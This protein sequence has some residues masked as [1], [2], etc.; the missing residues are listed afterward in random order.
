MC[1]E[2][3]NVNRSLPIVLFI[4]FC[5]DKSIDL[6]PQNSLQRAVLYDSTIRC[7]TRTPL[8]TYLGS[9]WVYRVDKLYMHN[10]VYYNRYF[11]VTCGFTDCEKTNQEHLSALSKV[12]MS[13]SRINRRF[14]CVYMM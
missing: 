3:L 10:I 9:E 8:T 11:K 12:A 13:K 7:L 1:V 6:K 5:I 4:Y 14:D 2:I